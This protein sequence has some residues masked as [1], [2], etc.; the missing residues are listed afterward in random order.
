MSS[1]DQT[2]AVLPLGLYERNVTGNAP[3]R[4]HTIIVVSAI[5]YGKTSF[6][7]Q[8]DKGRSCWITVTRRNQIEE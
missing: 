8:E 4:K 7:I 1:E 5:R 3:V 6:L 2:L